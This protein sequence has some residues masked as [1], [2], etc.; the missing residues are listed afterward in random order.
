MNYKLRAL[1]AILTFLIRDT[2]LWCTYVNRCDNVIF[3]LNAYRENILL[4]STLNRK[5]NEF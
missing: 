5:S 2:V 3:I 4:V 1:D